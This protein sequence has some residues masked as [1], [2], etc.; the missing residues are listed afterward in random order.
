VG[1]NVF[2]DNNALTT[3]LNGWPLGTVYH[4]AFGTAGTHG[5][6]TTTLAITYDPDTVTDP[7]VGDACGAGVNGCNGFIKG[8]PNAPIGMVVG[9]ALPLR[10][11]NI[12]RANQ[13]FA[14]A[15]FQSCP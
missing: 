8:A 15:G 4:S 7:T 3:V 2:N 5:L 14:F 6:D 1:D 11:C 12:K 10:E 13:S 9:N